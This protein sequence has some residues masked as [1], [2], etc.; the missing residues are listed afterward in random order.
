MITGPRSSTFD[1]VPIT[2]PMAADK[3]TIPSMAVCPPLAKGNAFD[4]IKPLNPTFPQR[5][6][7]LTV[8]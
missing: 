7:R 1:R 3:S 4:N 6:D 8:F 5:D 2:T